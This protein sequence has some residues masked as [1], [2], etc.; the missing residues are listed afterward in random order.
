MEIFN[1]PY[2]T[3]ETEYPESGT[4]AQLGGSYVF[5]T[6]STDP[7]QRKFTLNFK[8]LKYFVDDSG[9]IDDTLGFEYNL[10]RLDNFYQLHRLNTSFIYPHPVYGDVTVKFNKPLKIPKGLAGGNGIVE[11]ITIELLEIV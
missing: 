6:P 3:V 8:V 10:Q 9:T 5:T 11:D 1:F 2:H 4:R 7:E